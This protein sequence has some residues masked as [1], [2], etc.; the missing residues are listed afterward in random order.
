MKEASHENVFSRKSLI[1]GS[2]WSRQSLAQ[3]F[4]KNDLEAKGEQGKYI[5][6]WYAP[7][8]SNESFT[9]NQYYI[10]SDPSIESNNYQKKIRRKSGPNEIQRF[11]TSAMVRMISSLPPTRPLRSR[12]IT[13]PPTSLSPTSRSTRNIAMT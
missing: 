7:Y 5:S 11:S 10:L 4:T 6:Y 9:Y 3:P 12:P 1:F 2:I 8:T 13:R